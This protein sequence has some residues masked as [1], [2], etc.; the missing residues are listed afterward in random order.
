V[1][2][3]PGNGT[4]EGGRHWLALYGCL[5]ERDGERI[6]WYP[7]RKHFLLG[8][9]LTDEMLAPM[10]DELRTDKAEL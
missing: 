1:A 9:C 6:L 10:T 5:T 8:R 3:G 7:D 2:C 4:V